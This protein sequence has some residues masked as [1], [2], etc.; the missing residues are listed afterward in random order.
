MASR[1]GSTSVLRPTLLDR[2][3]E[4]LGGASHPGIGLRE[5]KRSVARDLEWLLN[6]RNEMIRS[7]ELANLSEARA[8]VLTYGVPDNSTSSRSS[9]NDR[10]RVRREIANAVRVFEPRLVPAT[11]VI[12]D[13]EES[14]DLAD[15][16]LRF[17]IEGTLHVEPIT[18]PVFFD[19]S[20]ELATGEFKID[21]S[22]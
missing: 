3:I 8:S 17:R 13:L 20:V 19:S 16:S 4:P 15:S 18:E 11:V 22:L 10:A 9:K 14:S 5:L 6:A 21:G 12:S 1:A 7:P 2:L